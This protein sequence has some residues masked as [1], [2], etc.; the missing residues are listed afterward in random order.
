MERQ[1]YEQPIQIIYNIT[2][3]SFKPPF[4][5]PHRLYPIWTTTGHYI[6]EIGS[7][8]ANQTTKSRKLTKQVSTRN[9]K[10]IL[11]V[12]PQKNGIPKDVL[13]YAKKKNVEI[14]EISGKALEE[15]NKIKGS[16]Y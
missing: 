2:L 10:K 9:R 12:P 14:R 1:I 7:K 5:N 13:E 4:S 3:W 8:Y 15:Y 6:N 16:M 11:E